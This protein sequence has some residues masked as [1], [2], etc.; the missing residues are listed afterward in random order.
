MEE[1]PNQQQPAPKAVDKG[2]APLTAEQLEAEAETERVREAAQRAE[3]QLAADQ[4]RA[5]EIS[6]RW[7]N[8]EQGRKERELPEELTSWKWGEKRWKWLPKDSQQAYHEAA[9]TDPLPGA[10]SDSPL[11]QLPLTLK[12]EKARR[13]RNNEAVRKHLRERDDSLSRYELRYNLWY[14]SHRDVDEALAEEFPRTAIRNPVGLQVAQIYRLIARQSFERAEREFRR[15]YQ[16]RFESSNIPSPR[17]DRPDPEPIG[18]TEYETFLAEHQL[19]LRSWTY[20]PRGQTEGSIGIR[21]QTEHEGP[22]RTFYYSPRPNGHELIDVA[23]AA[24]IGTNHRVHFSFVGGNLAAITGQQGQ[25][26]LTITELADSLLYGY[27]S[28]SATG[29]TARH[30]FDNLLFVNWRS[31]L[32]LYAGAAEFR[33]PL[34][35]WLSDWW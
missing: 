22:V 17:R 18:A 21:I 5:Q 3:A 27:F 34:D 25:V 24:L 31:Y 26:Q 20:E 33:D 2:K 15:E 6:D 30:L 11:P 23:N 9:T 13:I 7:R 14:N 35:D 19:S 12:Q 29:N 16:D 4:A 28:T 32:L 1:D 8:S 10:D